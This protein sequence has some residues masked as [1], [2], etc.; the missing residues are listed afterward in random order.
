MLVLPG[1]RDSEAPNLGDTINLGGTIRT[2]FR[3]KTKFPNGPQQQQDPWQVP[4]PPAQTV[5]GY[6]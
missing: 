5:L 2:L 6:G 1:V 4:S 3:G